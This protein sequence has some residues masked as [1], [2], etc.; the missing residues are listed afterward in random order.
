MS[1][2]RGDA[3]R[4]PH[5][6]AD[7]QTRECREARAEPHRYRHT[8]HGGSP[9]RTAGQA[10]AGSRGQ[11]Y[12]TGRIRRAPP[13]PTRQE[14]SRVRQSDRYDGTWTDGTCAHIASASRQQRSRR[15]ACPDDQQCSRCLVGAVRTDLDQEAGHPMGLPRLAAYA[16]LVLA[17]AAVCAGCS[18]SSVTGSPPPVPSDAPTGGA[19]SLAGWQKTLPLAGKH[20]AAAVVS[21]A[22]T[23][24]PWLNTDG[25]GARC[26]A[27]TGAGPA[28]PVG[29]GS[30]RPSRRQP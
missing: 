9:A 20:G 2:L 30:S 22:A 6:H 3:G 28:M 14:A 13:R 10:A 29:D 27:R 24:P 18:T 26:V 11:R 23:S 1:G 19:V 5:C 4:Q 17:V 15:H 25:S 21:P 8:H 12:R 16:G 7:E